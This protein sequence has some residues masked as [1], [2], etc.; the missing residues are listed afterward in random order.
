MIRTHLRVLVALVLGLSVL[1]GCGGD[2]EPRVKAKPPV[3]APAPAAPKPGTCYAYSFAEAGEATTLARPVPC[4]R[5]HTAQTIFVGR[6]DAI[7]DGHL[8]A[9]DSDRVVRQIAAACPRHFRD[10]IGGNE[11]TRRLSRFETVWFSP[12]LAQ[13]D[14]GETWFRCDLIALA[15]RE[16]LL[17]LPLRPR[18]ILDREGILDAFGTC[19]TARPDKPAFVRVAC[20]RP[21]AWRAVASV[22]LIPGAR[23]GGE[24]A[25]AA[26]DT[27]CRDVAATH[28]DDPLK[29]QWSFEWPNQDLWAAGQRWGLCWVPDRT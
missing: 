19:G 2:D 17:Q 24:R 15:G 28:S 27:A 8:V 6:I 16:Q 13:S 14:H 26:A 22:D 3:A 11:E 29:Y 21:H 25:T 7:H 23:Y 5:P 9:V 4:T 20:R 1:A 10:F 18:G 12:T